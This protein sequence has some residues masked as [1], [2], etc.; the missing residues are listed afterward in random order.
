MNEIN[1]RKL[2]YVIDTDCVDTK[3]LK[4]IIEKST[5]IST[6]LL[7][8]KALDFIDKGNVLTIR[9]LINSNK[10]ISEVK[11]KIKQQ[12]FQET[13]ET[14]LGKYYTTKDASNETV[15]H[16]CNIPLDTEVVQWFYNGTGYLTLTLNAKCLEVK[17]C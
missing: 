11:L 17:S 5:G 3:K 10:N 13:F 15:L 4:E 16:E 7:P 8:V 9:N 12:V 14:D 1:T 6:Q 2:V